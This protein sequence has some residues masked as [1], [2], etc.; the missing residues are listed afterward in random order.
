MS[1]GLEAQA[2]SLGIPMH[3]VV[4]DS[5]RYSYCSAHAANLV[6]IEGTQAIYKGECANGHEYDM[7]FEIEELRRMMTL[8]K[9]GTISIGNDRGFVSEGLQEY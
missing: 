7:E 1:L 2:N 3:I 5:L 4:D 8:N 6:S 9:D